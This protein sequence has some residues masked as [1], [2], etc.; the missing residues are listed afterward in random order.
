MKKY[1]VKHVWNV[2]TGLLNILILESFTQIY[3]FVLEIYKHLFV[4]IFHLKLLQVSVYF[5][6]KT[7]SYSFSRHFFPTWAALATE[8]SWA[9][10]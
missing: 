3:V 10:G 7:W 2:L 8:L 4:E 1:V 5:E 9:E 6:K